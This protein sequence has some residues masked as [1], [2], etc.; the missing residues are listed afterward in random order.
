MSQLAA[1]VDDGAEDDAPQPNQL[2]LVADGPLLPPSERLLS[3]RLKAG[4]TR[5]QGCG[6]CRT[7][8]FYPNRLACLATQSAAQLTAKAAVQQP[9]VA[10]HAHAKALER[11]LDKQQQQASGVSSR[12]VSS[13]LPP[14][15]CRLCKCADHTVAACPLNTRL[16]SAAPAEVTWADELDPHMRAVLLAGTAVGV[17]C[18][19]CAVSF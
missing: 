17:V 15:S 18:A 2:A 14:Q 1:L 4:E 3:S 7:C 11:Q 13:F 5:R 10:R 8:L 6:V 19:T 9:A 16:S 12:L